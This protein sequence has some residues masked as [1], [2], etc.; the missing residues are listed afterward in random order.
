MFRRRWRLALDLRKQRALAV[1]KC[2]RCGVEQPDEQFRTRPTNRPAERSSFC[3]TC[4]RAERNKWQREW[5]RKNPEKARN[6]ELKR[7][8]GITSEDY[9]EVFVEQGGIC[10]VC[11][12]PP[13]SV[14]TGQKSKGTLAV[15]HCHK[16]GTFR[17][18]L[19]TNCNL[20]L[21]SFFENPDLLLSAAAYI[22]DHQE[23]VEKLLKKKQQIIKQQIDFVDASLEELTNG[24]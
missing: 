9:D 18:L 22:K 17:G 7:R 21:G 2:S 23:L 11:R 16:T 24:P 20:G 4:A 3:I 12:R 8:H 15:D 13:G 10:A 19:C 1:R 14:G 5:Q 6:I